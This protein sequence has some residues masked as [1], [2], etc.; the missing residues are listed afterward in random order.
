MTTTL[1]TARPDTIK[2]H[3]ATLGKATKLADILAAEY[4][5]ISLYIVTNEDESQIVEWQTRTD[6]VMDQTG[7][8][9]IVAETI[10][11]QTAKV[12]ELADILEACEDLDIDPEEGAAPFVSSDVVDQHYKVQY[13]ESQSGRSCGDWLA[14]YLDDQTHDE[15]RKV[16]TAKLEDL[17]AANG[18]DM[19][20]SWAT[21]RNR[22]WQGRFRMSGRLALEKT[23][24]FNGI[25]KSHDG[26]VT[27]V[28]TE[29]LSALRAKHAKWIAK[30]QKLEDALKQ[31]A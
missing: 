6:I 2:A 10:I 25:V 27:E 31:D 15:K 17:F 18:L 13:R 28:P 24:A 30:Q 23:V 22:G 11:T 8:D 5:R 9:E 19:T 21:N 26:T 20:A 16:D 29:A 12:P 7:D 4:T 3:H 1:F 14:D